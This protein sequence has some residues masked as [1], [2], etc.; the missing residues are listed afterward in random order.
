MKLDI[1]EHNDDNMKL[2]I[3]EPD[4]NNLYDLRISANR[5]DSEQIDFDINKTKE[6]PARTDAD[7]SRQ[8]NDEQIEQIK[9]LLSK[10]LFLSQ[11]TP[12]VTQSDLRK[13][14][15]FTQNLYKILND[16]EGIN[17]STEIPRYVDKNTVSS[18]Q[19]EQMVHQYIKN[20][21]TTT[22][23][24][25][26]DQKMYESVRNVL[27][28]TEKIENATS[29]EEYLY[30]YYSIEKTTIDGI[31]E[32]QNKIKKS[33]ENVETIEEYY[34]KS[35]SIRQ[36]KFITE[37]VAVTV[38]GIGTFSGAI[39][40]ASVNPLLLSP[41]T[42]L[43]SSAIIGLVSLGFVITGILGITRVS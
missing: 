27:D 11:S 23:P 1:D 36:R 4:D 9:K 26:I 40:L 5:E 28:N 29:I 18:D 41:V 35:I 39:G 19:I 21:K 3:D 32:E 13:T 25:D 7:D 33:L 22:S 42:N 14:E 38:L 8:L 15:K 20:N 17:S 30:E 31:I 43:I 37:S 24:E 2:D 6:M 16:L 12:I 10:E 34:N